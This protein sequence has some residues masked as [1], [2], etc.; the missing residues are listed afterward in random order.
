M[1]SLREREREAKRVSDVVEVRAGAFGMRR[2][3]IFGGLAVLAA[4]AVVLAVASGSG[5][6]TPASTVTTVQ[7]E[8]VQGQEDMLAPV[9]SDDWELP[10]MFLPGPASTQAPVG[11]SAPVSTR[12][13]EPPEMFP[14]PDVPA[15]LYSAPVS[16][17]R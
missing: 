3:A 16:G 15:E 14:R 5:D 9:P 6:D 11:T 2:F 1:T 13:W 17:P 7:V 12:E 8:T 4:A 10:E